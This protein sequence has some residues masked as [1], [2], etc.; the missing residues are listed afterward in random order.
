MRPLRKARRTPQ[1]SVAHHRTNVSSVLPPLPFWPY[2]RYRHPREKYVTRTEYDEL[3]AKVLDLESLVHRLAPPPRLPLPSPSLDPVQGTVITPY[4]PPHPPLGPH[5]YYN[6]T[7]AFASASSR[8]DPSAPHPRPP[9]LIAP[10]SPTSSRPSTSSGHPTSMSMPLSPLEQGHFTYSP[11]APASI[12]SSS[13]QQQ[14]PP[15]PIPPTSRRASLSIAAIMAPN[16]PPH[17][18][19]PAP[20]HRAPSPSKK[21]TAQTPPPPGQRLRRELPTRSG[22]APALPPPHHRHH[23]PPHRP[24]PAAGRPCPLPISV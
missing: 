16:V 15:P 11:P 20:P 8:P 1:V 14:P 23:L 21:C 9:K 3:K 17:R 4:H 2:C 24:T 10:R 13:E 7:P 5:P 12:P 22:P 6:M 18:S 19:P